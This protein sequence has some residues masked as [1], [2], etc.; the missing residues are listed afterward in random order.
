MAGGEDGGAAIP[1]PS[2]VGELDSQVPQ[3]R[4]GAAKYTNNFKKKKRLLFRSSLSLSEHEAEKH[5]HPISSHAALPRR[6][7]EHF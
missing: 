2:L 6:R 3:L 1:V 4:P 5:R 7:R